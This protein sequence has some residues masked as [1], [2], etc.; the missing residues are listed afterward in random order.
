VDDGD[1]D[2]DRGNI[3]DDAVSFGVN[4]VAVGADP[5]ISKGG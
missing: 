2:D 4:V 3:A 1:D 5:V